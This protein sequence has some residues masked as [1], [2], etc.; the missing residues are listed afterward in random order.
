MGGPGHLRAGAGPQVAA[1]VFTGRAVN[2][3]QRCSGVVRTISAMAAARSA[4]VPVPSGRLT[5]S[6]CRDESRK[7]TQTPVSACACSTLSA[8]DG[9]PSRP[10]GGRISAAQLLQLVSHILLRFAGDLPA[11]PCSAGTVAERDGPVVAVLGSIA[12]DRV[13]A[14]A[15]ALGPHHGQGNYH[16]APRRS[17]ASRSRALTWWAQQVS[18]LR[19]LACKARV[20]G[21]SIAV[22]MA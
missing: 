16:L 22:G 19:P 1:L 14:V 3:G 11:E 18:N 8:L 4:G 7:R 9:L 15:A 21:R 12:V 20:L 6:W 2:D 10:A 13:F 17:S 5:I